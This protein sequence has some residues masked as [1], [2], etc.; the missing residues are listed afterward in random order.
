MMP[1]CEQAKRKP[2]AETLFR[3]FGDSGNRL[4][5]DELALV[6][7]KLFLI[8]LLVSYAGNCSFLTG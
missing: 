2:A 3:P 6:V 7:Q 5:G 1:E 8:L 4:S